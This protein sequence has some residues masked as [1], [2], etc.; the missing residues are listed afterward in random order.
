MLFYKA[1]TCSRKFLDVVEDQ[2]T[3]TRI[4]LVRERLLEVL[5]AAVFISGPG[6]SEQDKSASQF[7]SSHPYISS[8]TSELLDLS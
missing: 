2:I 5:G 4:P 3:Q 6:A 1:Q 8:I 7:S